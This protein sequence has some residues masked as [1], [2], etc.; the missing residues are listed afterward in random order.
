MKTMKWLLRREFW[1]HKGMFFWAPVIAAG[2]IA[3]LLAA[4][5]AKLATNA[6]AHATINGHPITAEV[7]GIPL[8]LKQAIASGM[9]GGYLAV[10]APLF[11][12]MG[13]AV[14]LYC[15]NS[16]Y[17]ERRDRSILFWKSLPLSDRDTV[18]SKIGAGIVMLPLIYIGVATV[19]SLVVLFVIA[20]VLFVKGINV[21]PVL[22][23]E[24]G[25]YLAPFQ[26]LGLLPVYVLWAL[27][28]VGWL[29]LVSVWARSKAFMWAVGVPLMTIA[30]LKF[31]TVTYHLDWNVDWFVNEIALR[32]M[33]GVFPGMW[34]TAE[35]VG[36]DQL[37]NPTTHMMDMTSVLRASYGTLSSPSVWGGV[38]AG[39]AMLAGSVRLRR[40]RD[41][42]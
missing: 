29:M 16:L 12:L 10:S 33:D 22:F 6:M 1:E 4:A 37:V 30:V 3:A 40:W 21:F 35:H 31:V 28:T 42:G 17:D 19:L 26:L 23:S 36:V 32:G 15:L 5:S 24:G 20:T 34:L 13:L 11:F 9:A 14:F 18:L 2:L 27:P 39:V 38:V 41:E 8:E 25:L 7:N